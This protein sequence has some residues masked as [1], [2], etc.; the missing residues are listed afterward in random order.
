MISHI[1]C[2]PQEQRQDQEEAEYLPNWKKRPGEDEKVNDAFNSWETHW[3][4]VYQE[5]MSL[6][7]SHVNFL[8]R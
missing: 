2:K 1:V 8:L 3:S 5:T 4:C 7:F 6:S